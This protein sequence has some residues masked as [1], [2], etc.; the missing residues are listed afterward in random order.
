MEGIPGPEA[1]AALRKALAKT[2]G[3][4]KAGII[5]SLGWRRDA[6]SVPLLVPLISDADTAIAKTTASALGRIGGEKAV[7]ALSA[8]HKNSNPEVRLAAA[9]ALLSCA[10]NRLSAGDKS[11][12]AALYGGLFD[13][14]APP[15]IRAAAWR[16]LVL[17]DDN[18]RPGLVVKALRGN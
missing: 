13:S 11:G 1:G 6:E 12:A 9:E 7:A 2:S 4:T 16:G 5:D 3:L 8:A 18:Q 14:D 17:S 10:E 15:A